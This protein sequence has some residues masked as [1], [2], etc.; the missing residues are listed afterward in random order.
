MADIGRRRVPKTEHIDGGTAPTSPRWWWKG[1]R[2]EDR[3][4]ESDNCGVGAIFSR[5][6]LYFIFYLLVITVISNYSR[7]LLST[8]DISG[9]QT[10]ELRCLH[11]VFR[12]VIFL[13]ELEG[14]SASSMEGR[15]NLARLN[16]LKKKVSREEIRLT[17][18]RYVFL[19]CV[20][21]LNIGFPVFT[22]FGFRLKHTLH[23]FFLTLFF[24]YHKNEVW[25]ERFVPLK[26]SID[27]QLL[28]LCVLSWNFN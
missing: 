26:T 5:K 21:K 16:G 11:F 9:E 19:L 13:V 17:S 23:S 15:K 20:C 6:P 18:L 2:R 1:D 14:I 10:S 7:L 4:L 12:V 22:Y 25:P 8:F 3:L 27:H 28:S 24:L